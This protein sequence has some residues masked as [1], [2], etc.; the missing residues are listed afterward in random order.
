M[1]NLPNPECKP[2]AGPLPRF[3]KSN[4]I[5]QLKTGRTEIGTAMARNRALQ[6]LCDPL[7]R[8]IA[9]LRVPATQRAK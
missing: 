5:A 7:T 4:F 9:V 6:F 1:S 3:G 2:L 8:R